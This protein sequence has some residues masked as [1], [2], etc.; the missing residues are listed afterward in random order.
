MD[1][2]IS[3]QPKQRE[4]I[5]AC[6]TYENVFFGGAKGG[7]KSHVVRAKELLR[8][9]KYAGT[10][11]VIIR[12]TYDELRVN[13]IQKFFTEYPQTRKWYNKSE[14]TIHY[15]NGST[16][17]F[18]F[19]RRTEDVYNFQGLEFDD[20][21][22]DEATQHEGVVVKILASS[23]RT[24]NPDIKPNFFLT[25]N[26][27]GVGHSFMKRVFIDRNFKPDEDP[28]TYHFI[29]A[30]VF[31]NDAIIKNDPAYLKRLKALPDRLR[32]A[33]LDGDWNI[34]AGLA[35]DE[36]DSIHIAKPF[37][38]PNNTRFIAGYDYG[39]AH[40]FSWILIAITPDKKVY[41][42]DY[43]KIHK[44]RPDEQGKMIVDKIN[45]WELDHLY[46]Y[47]GT[48]IWSDKE[49]RDTIWEQLSKAVGK[50]ATFLKAYTDRKAGVAEMRKIIAWRNTQSG[51]PQL[52]FF[53]NTLD[54]FD[55]IRGMQ[56]DN[57]RL[58]D[59]VKV[60][61]DED[62]NGGDDLYDGARYGIMARLYP[63]RAI[64][65]KIKKNSGAELMNMV[66]LQRSFKR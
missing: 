51:E 1:I 47:S 24:T 54:V 58:E 20:I 26:P 9:L 55:Q 60:N 23:L 22:L 2:K 18:K 15:P 36:L 63:N 35:F 59:V 57:K 48:D 32:K 27:G 31:D 14:K 44:K 12:K 30:K 16:T 34:F 21:S 64:H 5:K 52:K 17:A 53:E 37:R 10:Y 28:E 66:R 39:Y 46:I 49:G 4:A 62:G 6:E 8:R 33:Y 25:G 41:I 19:L 50:K 45:E 3:L 13:H 7:G 42:V 65:Q 38:L 11:G 29:P 61:A 56:V 40:P 43:L